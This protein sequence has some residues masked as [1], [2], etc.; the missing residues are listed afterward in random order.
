MGFKVQALGSGVEALSRLE[1]NML[2][3]DPIELIMMDW[4]MPEMD[5]IETSR[6]IRRELKLTMPIIMMTAFGKDEQRIE[7]EKAGINGF[8]TKPIYPST[9][10][11]AIMD[12]FGKEGLKG[13][14]RKKQFT[15]RASMYRKPLKGARI[16][17]AEDN[18]TNQQVAQAILE[19]A[20]IVVTI[21]NNGQAA[22]EAVQ[23]QTFDAVLMDIQMPKMNGYEATQLIRQL[24]RGRSLPIAAMTAHAM[25][26][27]E[28]K[29][30]EAG[31]DG[32]ISKP[33]HQD[34]LFQTLWRILRSRTDSSKW[35]APEEDAMPDPNAEM[36]PDRLPGIDIRQTLAVLNIDTATFTRILT[37]FMADNPGTEEKLKQALAGSDLETLRQLAHSLKGS[38][39]NIGANDLRAAAR[40]LEDAIRQSPSTEM[41]RSGLEGLI[42]EVACALNQV[43]QSI[44]SLKAPASAAPAAVASVGSGAFDALLAQLIEAIDHADP[45]QIAALMPAVRRQAVPSGRMDR[46]MLASLEEKVGRY[47]YDQA[48]EMLRKISK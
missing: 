11:D 25:K 16:L 33:I 34:R 44:R 21:V 32:Y 13:G 47:D 10:F 7:A 27:D 45:Q 31:M 12:G 40:A 28:E 22:V 20:G 19:G 2:R 24:P 26:G 35:S 30:L 41:D 18:P 48:L 14:G 23:N 3:N 6:K 43:L 29:C 17:V 39:A 1:D 36:L 4:K 42:Q 37:G 46:G 8:L 9:L 15:T 38:A 5:G